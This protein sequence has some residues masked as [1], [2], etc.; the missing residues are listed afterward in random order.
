MD[1]LMS[2]QSWQLHWGECSVAQDEKTNNNKKK[3]SWQKWTVVSTLQEIF[4]YLFLCM[5]KPKQPK[6]PSLPVLF[7][8]HTHT[9]KKKKEKKKERR[10][11][12][13][14]KNWL[15]LQ[16]EAFKWLKLTYL[17]LPWCCDSTW[18]CLGLPGDHW[19]CAVNTHMHARM[20]AHTHTCTHTHTHMHACTHTHT[21]T[22]NRHT[23]TH[24]HTHTYTHT[25]THTHTTIKLAFCQ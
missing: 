7:H 24:I 13:K 14:N 10:K 11:Q 19:T 3:K 17:P 6:L 21:H 18:W 2:S 5:W 23:H 9:H 8:T 15:N 20:H 16:T 12:Q 4:C 22:H 1:F 25:H